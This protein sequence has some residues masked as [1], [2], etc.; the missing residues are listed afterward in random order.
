MNIS[1]AEQRALHVLALGGLI[2]H[3]RACG[4]KV[5]EVT[6]FTREGAVLSDCDLRVFQSLRR[7]GLIESR[8]GAP[9]RISLRGRRMVR[10]QHDNQGGMA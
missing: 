7:K 6:C 3:E 10:A 9:Y 1:R 2:R 5:S 8:N 4:R